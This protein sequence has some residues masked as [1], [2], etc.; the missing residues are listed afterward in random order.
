[1]L[2]EMHVEITYCICLCKLNIEKV[3]SQA[4]S[5]VIKYLILS[6]LVSNAVVSYTSKNN[7]SDIFPLELAQ[8]NHLHPSDRSR[9]HIDVIFTT[10]SGR[11]T[12]IGLVFVFAHRFHRSCAYTRKSHSLLVRNL[13]LI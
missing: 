2:S 10:F 12:A 13:R 11:S 3:V 6:Y 4:P 9:H 8:S 5:A 1:M 7:Q